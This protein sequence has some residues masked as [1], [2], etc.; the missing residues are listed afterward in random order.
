MM[1]N[2]HSSKK[3]LL[4]MSKVPSKNFSRIMKRC[5]SNYSKVNERDNNMKLVTTLRKKE[6]LTAKLKETDCI[7]LIDTVY[8]WADLMTKDDL[9]QYPVLLALALYG[10]AR[11]EG[12]IAQIAVGEVVLNRYQV[13]KAVVLEDILLQKKQ[14]ACFNRGDKSL[15]NAIQEPFSVV[16]QFCVLAQS[17]VDQVTIHNQRVMKPDTTIYMTEQAWKRIAV[18]W[19]LQ[20]PGC[21]D[22]TKLKRR[23]KIEK[24]IFFAE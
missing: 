3:K 20:K 24:H 5:A 17:I 7:H 11:G 2:Y 18:N 14:F 13:R 6:Q 22:I 19:A 1:T 10:E 15:D 4:A 9:I 8:S 16:S 12:I 23:G 21:W